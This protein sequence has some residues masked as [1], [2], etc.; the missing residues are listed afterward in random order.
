MSNPLQMWST[1]EHKERRAPSPWCEV[2]Q[3]RHQEIEKGKRCDQQDAQTSVSRTLQ[4]PDMLQPPDVQ[5][6]FTSLHPDVSDVHQSNGCWAAHFHTSRTAWGAKPHN[7]EVARSK[8]ASTRPH[9]QAE[10]LQKDHAEDATTHTKPVIFMS[11]N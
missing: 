2:M 3:A 4:P 9:G 11:G 6:C 10:K 5:I 8:L 7:H 1:W